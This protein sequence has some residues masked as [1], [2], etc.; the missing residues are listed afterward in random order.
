MILRRA[1]AAVSTI[2]LV[3]V[4]IALA[5]AAL[6]VLLLVFISILG[7]QLSF[8]VGDRF[9]QLWQNLRL[10]PAYAAFASVTVQQGGV[11]ASLLF[12]FAC[13]AGAAA[14][15]FVRWRPA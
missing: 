11:F 6:L 4:S 7:L 10:G 12:T 2:L 3:F 14:L 8:Q 1:A 5:E 15:R 9:L 13:G